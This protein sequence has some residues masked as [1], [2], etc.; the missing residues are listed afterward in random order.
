M[1]GTIRLAI[2]PGALRAAA[3]AAAAAWPTS[4][5][6]R[7]LRTQSENGRATASTSLSSGEARPWWWVAW[8]PITLTIGERARRALWTLASPLARPG[9]RWSSVTAGLPAIRA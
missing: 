8:S 3:I 5:G 6:V 7:A 9:P 2:W 4:G 1:P